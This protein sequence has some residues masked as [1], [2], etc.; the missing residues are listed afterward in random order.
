MNGPW[1]LSF[2]PDQGLRT[3][4]NENYWGEDKPKIDKLDLAKP[5]RVT[6]PS[7]TRALRRHRLPVISLAASYNQRSAVEQGLQRLPVAR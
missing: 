5:S 4:P 3:I 1:K 6:T 2:T 7:S